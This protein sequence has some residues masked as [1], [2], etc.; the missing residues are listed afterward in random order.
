MLDITRLYAFTL[1]INA[2]SKNIYEQDWFIIKLFNLVDKRLSCISVQYTW[3]T[4]QFNLHNLFYTIKKQCSLL[5]RDSTYFTQ[6]LSFKY[7]IFFKLWYFIQDII[8][9]RWVEFPENFLSN[10]SIILSQLCYRC[11][12]LMIYVY[13]I[14]MDR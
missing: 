2:T 7:S 9:P 6:F 5:F 11:S 12:I 14:C 13:S 4:I 8:K 10:M 1:Y 3:I